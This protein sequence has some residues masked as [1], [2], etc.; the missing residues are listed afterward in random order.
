MLRLHPSFSIRSRLA[1][2]GPLRPT[3]EAGALGL[4]ETVRVVLVTDR[5]SDGF[6]T[7]AW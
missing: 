5:V 6:A 3:S 7:G 1:L 2:T 4:K